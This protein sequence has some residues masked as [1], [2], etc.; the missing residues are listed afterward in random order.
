MERNK[1]AIISRAKSKIAQHPPD[2]F[3]LGSKSSRD[4]L[5][6]KRPGVI[7]S[8]PS[9]PASSA[10][11]SSS[12]ERKNKEPPSGSLQ[13]LIPAK[14]AKLTS[15][16]I[17][18]PRPP[19]SSAEAWEVVAIDCEPPD[20]VPM[21][22]EASDNDEGDKVIGLICGAIKTLKNQRWKPDS[23]LSIG[24]MYLAKIRPSIFSNDCVV[25]ALSSLL[26]RD[27]AHNFKSKGNPLVPVLAA[28]LLMR[29][30]HDRKAWPEVF[31]KLYIEDALGE[32]V[33]V[34][35]DECKGFTDN[36]LTSLCTRIP[37]KSA[38][39]HELSLLASRD[40][41]SPS[42]MEDDDSGT[43]TTQ[44]GDKDKSEFTVSPR[45]AH[46]PETVETMVLDLVKEQLNRRQPESITK[47]VLKLLS[48][49]CGLVEIRNL[50]L[51][52]IE[53]WLHN[54][55]LMKPAQ[56]LL[57]YI[58]FNCTTHT[59][60][61]VEV[62]SQLVKLRLKTKAVV[63]LYL[64]GIKEL[65]GLHPENLSTMMKHT[66]YNELSNAR[67]SNNM[68]ML[69]V[70]FQSAPEAS[71]K[72]LAEIFQ[73]LLMNRE[74]FLRPLRALF[75]E[76]IR[77]CR[78]DIN[79]IT[80]AKALMKERPQILQ[81]IAVFEFK[82][83]MF[84]SI[85]DL[86][87]LCMFLAISPQVKEVVLLTQ[88]GEKKDV[89]PLQQFQKLVSTIQYDTTDWLQRAQSVYGVG[90][91]ELLKAIPKIMLLESPEHYYKLDNWPPETDR[92]LFMRIV[93]EVPLLQTTLLRIM[94]IGTSKEI[95]N[96]QLEILDFVDQLVRRA[97][98][99]STEAFPMLQADQQDIIELIFQLCVY[100]PPGS[101]NIP[102]GYTPPNLAISNC[103]W[104]GWTILLILAA[105]NPTTI[106]ETGWRRYPI[107][108]TLM[109]MCITNYFSYPPPTL[110]LP[111]IIEQERTKE[112]QREAREKLEILEYESHLAAA[113]TKVQI[114]ESNSL[115]LSQL[116]TMDPTGIARRPPSA[117]L[118]QIQSLNVSHRL[119]HLLCRSRKPDF[120]LE[121]IRR[122][123][124]SSSQSMPWLADLV[125]NSEGSLSQLPVQ[126]LCEFLLS[127]T[128]QAVDKQPRHQQ[129]LGHLQKFL[130]DPNENPQHANEVLEYFLRRLQSPQSNSRMQA[131]AGLKLVLDSIPVDEEVM[132]VDG[133]NEYEV[134][135]LKK[136]PSIPNFAT[137]IPTPHNS[138]R[139][140]VSHILRP[141]CLVENNPELVRA[142]IAYLA[143]HTVD[144][145][146]PDFA[147]LANDMAQLVVERSTITA[148]ILPEPDSDCPQAR[149]TL[150]A[151][152]TIFC[153]YLR[154]ARSPSGG[155]I[156]WSESQDQIL[157]QWASKEE[158]TMHILVVHAMIILL[159]YDILDD[160]GLSNDLLETWFP[161]IGDPPKAYLVDTSEEALLIPDWLK[162]RMIRS[163]VPRLVD[164][165]LKDLEPQQLVLFIQSFGI[166]I[167]S[168][169]KLLH[170][171]DVAVQIDRSSVGEAVLDKAYMAQLVKVQHHRGATGG[172][173]FVKV[174]QLVEPQL[175]EAAAAGN[176]KLQ[177]A[178][179]QSAMIKNQS[180]IQYPVKTEVPHLI[181]KLFIENIP[182]LQKAEAYRRLHKTLAKNLQK[183]TKENGAIILAIQHICSVLSS[184]QVEQFLASLVH[185]PQYSCTLMRI[186]LLPLKKSGTPTNLV[187]LGKNMCLNLISLIGDVKAPILSILRDFADV[188]KT[189]TARR[190]DLVALTKTREPSVILENTDSV[191]LESVGRTLLDILLKN[192]DNN[193]L[194]N[195]MAQS[196]VSDSNE[197]LVKPR[198]GLLIDWLASIEPELIGVCP[199]LQMKLLFG[200][201]KLHIKID[202]SIVNSHTYRPYLL[203]LLTH[204][205]SWATLYKCVG[206]L[207]NKCD[208]EY[209]PT[210]VLDFLWALTCNPKL[211]QGR[212]KFTP[213]HY[214]PEDILLLTPQQLLT[215]VAYV[216]AEAVV[217]HDRQGR[218]AAL[219]QMELRL[220]LL[221]HCLSTK[222]KRIS[223]V[224]KYLAER[225]VD[226]SSTIESD[227]AHQ[228]LLHMYMKIPKVICFL[229]QF[230]A[231]KFVAGA[232]I[233]DWTGSVL[234][235]MSH[236]LLTALAAT[237]RQ[238]S[239]IS[240]SQ[241]FELCARKM[242]AV[243]PILVLRQLPMLASSL[244]GRSHL[245]MIDFR[246]GHHLNL[247]IQV[248]GLLELLQPYLFNEEHQTALENTLE[249]YFQCFQNYGNYKDHHHLI[250][251][252][253][254]FVALLQ[255]Y[256]SH[257]AQRALKY[258]HSRVHLLR[259]L[260]AYYSGVVSLRSLINAIPGPREGTNG[261]EIFLAGPPNINQKDNAIP[262]NWHFMIGSLSKI[263]GEDV[264]TALLEIEQMSSRK[265]SI[266]DYVTDSLTELLVSPQGNIRS[267]AHSLLA[268]ALK[269]KPTLNLT[270]LSAFQRCLDSPR[271]DVLMSALDRLPDVVLCMQEH[272]LPLLQ[273]VFELGVNSNVNTIP[274]ITKSIMLLNIQQGC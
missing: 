81:Q 202:D 237:P 153:N 83:R 157:V 128:I 55:K 152:K 193:I 5:E 230:Q 75:R 48:S 190:N 256:I 271:S 138:V 62:I 80:L 57:I 142:Y 182:M 26:K 210:A 8:K 34:D 245:D 126:C 204:R 66:I 99:N 117:V 162:L 198:T 79:L 194:V 56:E 208:E 170:T 50:V 74:D 268:K 18:H 116:I 263:Q 127:T 121:I 159:T 134:W 76:I 234:D 47:N 184:M 164:A 262:Q 214:V 215:L 94:M 171:L 166:P 247:F 177:E 102:S 179:P 14:K 89:A 258:L 180:V 232:K 196:L 77:V 140:M 13:S 146:L 187:D 222:E 63:N 206:H 205:A 156:T 260:Q 103:Y 108:Q 118:E 41:H 137:Y 36:I 231:K 20:L 211:W 91:V 213:K 21:V 165:A 120:L 257:D 30:F 1:P 168:M 217:V 150:Q 264:L 251:L 246:T 149:Q 261:E 145:D 244:T 226:N 267:L 15:H 122:Q 172:L 154:K 124:Q 223:D 65:I 40:C 129:L 163:N 78:H 169:S 114:S 42:T 141:A 105:H 19:M 236:S 228:F 95:G 188:Q 38:L 110:A 84:A 201:S 243:H 139:G 11:S 219:T 229:N 2:L 17:S 195:A 23:L 132:E 43:S 107:L 253:N 37:P 6:S 101:I 96:C 64:N 233:T 160:N 155:N 111:E 4:V 54:P 71:A 33:W 135:L 51:P 106:G 69:A 22:L 203:T 174:L 259:E 143:E 242:A 173:V 216:V 186:I 70:M 225:M 112:L 29:G 85:I 197:G 49:A 7:H 60:R 24:L 254:R 240:K 241:E 265:P 31:L 191:N 119:G 270:I 90:K 72:L 125:Q 252:L 199:V 123:Q 115:L 44:I 92:V 218:N 93:C 46:C 200:K 58:C 192:A 273:K 209:D 269:H 52:R 28:N 248:M 147:D 113:S 220:D 221:Q 100:Q 45:Y 59:Q 158:C 9:A 189:K 25:H 130:T 151:L 86:L 212:D 39:Q 131:I 181:N 98:G 27:Q 144:D 53:V 32:R 133:N 136:L 207:L 87:C 35:H 274:H 272:A 97:A 266:F 68:P 3:A 255:A 148:A 12:S 239:W 104:K 224:V 167:S 73:D 109:E 178:L 82:E 176:E 185:M 250:T 238:K 61:D 235:C 175:L 249:N 16:V 10:S 161:E 227:M 88:R 67:N 183:S